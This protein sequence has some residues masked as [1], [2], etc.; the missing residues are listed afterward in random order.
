[1]NEEKMIAEFIKQKEAEYIAAGMTKLEAEKEANSDAE[2]KF[3]W[4]V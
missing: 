3:W 1:M 4:V 2:L